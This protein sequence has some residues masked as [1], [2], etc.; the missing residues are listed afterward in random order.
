LFSFPLQSCVRHCPATMKAVF[1]V[2]L[3]YGFLLPD[4]GATGIRLADDKTITKVVK[5][6]QGMLD[7][8]KVDGDTDAELYAKYKCYCDQND[9]EKTTTV[10]EK[11]KEIA[12]LTSRIEQLQAENGKLS[13]ESAKL[14]ADIAATEDRKAAAIGIRSQEKDAYDLLKADL[15]A[16]MTKM[17]EAIKVLAAIG[18]DQSLAK[19]ADHDKFMANYQP[20]LIVKVK[21]Q[22]KKALTAAAAFVPHEKRHRVLQLIQAPFTGTY[23]TQ[24]VEVIGILKDMYD[25]F[26]ANLKE[27]T[28][29]E[30]KAKAAHDALVLEL[31]TAISTMTTLNGKKQ[32][33]LSSNDDSLSS[34]KSSLSAAETAKAEAEDFLG[35]L[36]TMCSEKAKEFSERKM[37]RVNEEAAIAQAIAILNSD[38]AFALFGT[39]SATST[40]ATE[41]ASFLQIRRGSERDSS[42]STLV[43]RLER[44]VRSQRSMKLA[45]VLALLRAGNPFDVVLGEIAKMLDLISKEGVQDKANL[46]FCN[47]ERTAKDALISTKTGEISDLEAKETDLTKDIEDPETGLKKQLEENAQSLIQNRESKETETK[48]RKEENVAY[49]ADIKNLVDTEDTLAKAIAVLKKYY[50]ELAAKLAGAALMQKKRADPAPPTT[51]EAEEGYKGQS[52]KGTDAITMLQFI[53]SETKKEEEQAHLEEQTSQHSYEDSMDGLVTAETDLLSS[54]VNL[55]KTLADKEEELANTKADLEKTNKEKTSLEEYLLSIKPG[56]DFITTNFATRESYRGEETTALNTAITTI[57]ASPAYQAAVTAAAQAA[58][59]MCKDIC[60]AE[61]EA[62]VKCKACL[63]GVTVPGYCAGHPTTTGC[64]S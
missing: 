30:E 47:S 25:T 9:E 24:S 7:K 6:L 53:L 38:E 56:C 31:D 15:E 59:G 4:Q 20:S 35:K 52:A 41:A 45:K 12:L 21:S 18:A 13:A 39:V 63:A 16:A 48:V 5:L 61:G 3:L 44:T 11:T 33:T 23:T 46:D 57:K 34:D 8:S 28:T 36:A 49:Q 50:D 32:D 60:N 43:Q 26:D 58:L 54:K 17:D 29:T 40:G 37:M 64:S 10:D 14:V 19:G 27:A 51:W 55:E 62:H 42:V 2:A 22:V 1:G